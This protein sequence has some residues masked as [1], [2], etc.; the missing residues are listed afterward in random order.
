MYPNPNHAYRFFIL[1]QKKTHINTSNNGTQQKKWT[2]S[3]LVF[4]C[5]SWTCY[6]E[7]ERWTLWRHL[8]QKPKSQLNV[9][10]Q[11]YRQKLVLFKLKLYMYNSPAFFFAECLILF[12]FFTVN[13]YP[14]FFKFHPPP[15]KNQIVAPLWI[16]FVFVQCL[17]FR[18]RV[19]SQAY[20]YCIFNY[21][22]VQ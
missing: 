2:Y 15:L 18:T 1:D 4:F 17:S 22:A 20:P 8:S 16:V 12:F 14:V 13:S 6:S 10:L 3:T 11:L 5:N 9:V 19:W 7:F 21:T